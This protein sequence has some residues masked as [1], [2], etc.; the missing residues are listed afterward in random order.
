MLNTDTRVVAADRARRG[1]DVDR[2]RTGLTV[3]KN[4]KV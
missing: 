1:V 3:Y 2:P 4:A